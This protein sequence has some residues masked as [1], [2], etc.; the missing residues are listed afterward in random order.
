[1]AEPIWNPNPNVPPDEEPDLDT[2]ALKA[3]RDKLFTDAGPHHVLFKG[4]LNDGQR[5]RMRGVILRYSNNVTRAAVE[6]LRT[7]GTPETQKTADLIEKREAQNG[8]VQEIGDTHRDLALVYDDTWVARCAANWPRV[9]AAVAFLKERY[10]EELKKPSPN[11]QRV[12]AWTKVEAALKADEE[13]RIKSAKAKD[14]ARSEG[15][16]DTQA[17]IKEVQE[18]RSALAGKDQVVS[19]L[20]RRVTELEAGAAPPLPQGPQ[21]LKTSR[22][23]P[24]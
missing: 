7:Y 17:L 24:R 14:S 2:K 6:G 13:A 5:Q 16:G 23:T 19:A 8:A 10:E 15:A 11:T 3:D 12:A 20:Q 4:M 18:L 9:Q 22:R 21:G 1:M